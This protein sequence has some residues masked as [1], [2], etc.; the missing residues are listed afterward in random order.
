[1]VKDDAGKLH[2]LAKLSL[3]GVDIQR[4]RDKPSP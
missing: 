3:T 2:E 1:M 4:E